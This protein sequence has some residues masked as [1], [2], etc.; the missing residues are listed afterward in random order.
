MRCLWSLCLLISTLSANAQHY[1]VFKA[2]GIGE[3]FRDCEGKPQRSVTGHAF[4]SLVRRDET[5]QQTIV[6]STWGFV[7]NK[8][9][10]MALVATP[11]HSEATCIGDLG[12]ADFMIEVDKATY[13]YAKNLKLKWVARQYGIFANVNC[14]DFVKAMLELITPEVKLPEIPTGGQPNTGGVAAGAAMSRQWYRL[15]KPFL[16]TLKRLNSVRDQ[17]ARQSL[18]DAN[19]PASPTN[20]AKSAL[21][22]GA[23]RLFS[24]T[25]TKASVAEKNEI[26]NNLQFK[27]ANDKQQFT[28]EEGENY[29]FTALVLPT[30]M[31]GDGVDELFVAFG[32][33]FT[34][35]NTGSEIVLFIK[36]SAGHYEKNLNFSGLVPEALSTGNGGYADLLIGGPDF[37]HPIWRWD[38]AKYTFFR[39][40]NESVMA[41]LKR[42]SIRA[43]SQAYQ[44]TIR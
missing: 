41:T 9:G 35:G 30:D 14:V 27:L 7:P 43:L 22:E 32:N 13:E 1:F 33:T 39:K 18:A 6:D 40:V 10:M 2:R 25:R 12:S 5:L 16:S 8:R 19:T 36:N 3:T 24:T 17:E 44:R 34:S 23:R 4:V 29:P 15:P 38:G 31:N 26:Y 11:G 37:E 28:I 20:N 21:S 42:T